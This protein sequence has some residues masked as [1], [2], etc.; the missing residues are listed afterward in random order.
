MDREVHIVQRQKMRGATY[1]EERQEK[2]HGYGSI[3]RASTQGKEAFLVA[4]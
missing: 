4:P 1:K 2:L 3:I